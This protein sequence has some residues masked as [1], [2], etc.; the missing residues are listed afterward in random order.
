MRVRITVLRKARYDDI[1]EK[2]ENPLG[3]E[4][5]VFENQVFISENGEKPSGLC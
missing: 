4:C 2:Y 5:D 1:I 3:H